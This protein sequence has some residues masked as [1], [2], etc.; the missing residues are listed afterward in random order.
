[1]AF[2]VL[3]GG[4]NSLH[5]PGDNDSSR[6]MPC[7]GN[8]KRKMGG[9]AHG[10]AEDERASYDYDM[11][12]RARM[13]PWAGLP[14]G[15]GADSGYLHRRD[16]VPI[17][18]LAFLVIR[19]GQTPI[20]S[21]PSPSPEPPAAAI[22]SP[23]PSPGPASHNHAPPGFGHGHGSASAP[24]CFPMER[25]ESG[26]S[27]S[28][29]PSPHNALSALVVDDDDDIA[30]GLVLSDLAAARLV[31]TH[32]AS[33]R[34]RFPDSQPE[35]IL[36]ALI[37]PKSRGA[38]FPLDNDAL[39]SI[40]SA[41][42]ELFFASRLAR[43]VAWDWSHPACGQYESHIVGTT[44][45]R[46]C[47]RLG[48]WETLIVL[49]TPILRDTKY[50]R[51]LLISTFLHEMIH[52]FMF[53][54][55]G[56]KASHDGGHTDGFRQIAAVIDEWAGKEYLRLSDMEANLE[57]FRGDDVFLPSHNA[58]PFPPTP[59]SDEGNGA[60]TH[61]NHCNGLDD[62]NVMVTEPQEWPHAHHRGQHHHH[63]AVVPPS[64]SHS[65]G[66]VF[67]GGWQWYER[68]DFGARS[69]HASGSPYVY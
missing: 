36:R 37:T 52:S 21:S 50:N 28:S 24:P 16:S 13:A 51:R 15:V 47:T 6:A 3:G 63:R 55:C 32:L 65:A 61:I 27:I 25:T 54:T 68:E 9:G 67:S 40:F 31:R 5:V 48:G 34:R 59:L 18:D 2:W 60:S 64:P 33:F 42:N 29:A 53:V 19:E 35:R 44:A 10:Q 45:L 46:R 30:T 4:G 14:P 12:K 41:A 43:R 8:G 7:F 26:L 20:C 17:R 49:S 69:P 58:F 56:L 22:A 11:Q 57:R 66:G 23:V 1:M 62:N 38:D 39:G